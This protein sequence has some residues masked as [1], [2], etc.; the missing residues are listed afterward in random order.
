MT[1]K[2]QAKKKVFI[3]GM[4]A[5]LETSSCVAI[6]RDAIDLSAVGATRNFSVKFGLEV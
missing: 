2:K 4:P 6:R 3:T 1:C 5:A